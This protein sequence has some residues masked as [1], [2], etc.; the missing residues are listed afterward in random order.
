ME[1]LCGEMEYGEKEQIDTNLGNSKKAKLENIR[2]CNILVFFLHES[3][4]GEND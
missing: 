4:T 3:I 1:V 2:I